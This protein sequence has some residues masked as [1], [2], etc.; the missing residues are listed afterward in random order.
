MEFLQMLKVIKDIMTRR[1]YPKW[2]LTFEV[3]C[4]TL[5]VLSV[6]SKPSQTYMYLIFAPLVKNVGER[7]QMYLN[8]RIT[9]S[10]KLGK[11]PEIIE[12]TFDWSPLCQLDPVISWTFPSLSKDSISLCRP[13][14]CLATI[15]MKKFLMLSSLNL[16]WC[17]LRLYSF[18]LSLFTW[19]KGPNSFWSQLFPVFLLPVSCRSLRWYLALMLR[20]I[21]WV[22]K[23]NQ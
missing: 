22:L 8:Y 15:S 16:S 14:Q 9:E 10:F 19:E 5:N 11:N 21:R 2:Y 7:F 13:F 3:F 4:K 17:S 6:K 20:Q 18:V 1:L 23:V 12:S